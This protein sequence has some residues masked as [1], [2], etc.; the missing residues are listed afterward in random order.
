MVHNYDHHYNGA[1][2]VHGFIYW[3]Y[4][5]FKSDDDLRGIIMRCLYA[6]VPVSFVIC[7]RI[8]VLPFE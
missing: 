8:P 4:E 1:P 3:F 5:N 2:S 6:G 7:C